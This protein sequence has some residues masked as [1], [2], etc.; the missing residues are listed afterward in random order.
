[1]SKIAR[2]AADNYYNYVDVYGKQP[3]SKDV[4]DWIERIKLATTKHKG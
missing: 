3:R 4:D 1:M 2:L